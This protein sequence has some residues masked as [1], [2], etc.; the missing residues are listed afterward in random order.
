MPGSVGM[1]QQVTGDVHS[2]RVNVCAWKRE[3]RQRM[4][5]ICNT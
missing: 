1:R 3:V 2:S 5:L 4:W